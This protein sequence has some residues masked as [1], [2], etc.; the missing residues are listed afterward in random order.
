MSEASLIEETLRLVKQLDATDDPVE[1]ALLEARIAERSDDL[2]D[3]SG[4]VVAT[5]DGEW[6]AC[7]L[8]EEQA[9]A[10]QMA[11]LT[12]ESGF[13]TVVLPALA[14]IEDFVHP[15][16]PVSVLTAILVKET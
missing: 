8:D 5:L 15:E 16:T 1:A 12:T 10:L 4:F 2:G 9:R 13:V 6:L 11:L 14:S 7:C 3:L